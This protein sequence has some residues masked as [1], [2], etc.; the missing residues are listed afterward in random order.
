MKFFRIFLPLVAIMLYLGVHDGNLALYRQG[1]EV[2]VQVYAVPISLFPKED[3]AALTAGIP[4]ESQ[5]Q[6]TELLEAYLS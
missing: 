4:I 2:P 3:Q 5:K 6:L 1:H